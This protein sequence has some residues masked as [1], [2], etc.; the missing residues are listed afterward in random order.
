MSSV[1]PGANVI[2]SAVV[3]VDADT[4]AFNKS[5]GKI[6]GQMR[7][8]A[9]AAMSALQKELSRVQGQI[10]INQ[11][12]QVDPADPAGSGPTRPAHRPHFHRFPRKGWAP[13]P[14]RPTSD[15][16][17]SVKIDK[18]ADAIAN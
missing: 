14:G 17:K 1:G 16:G 4:L 9:R 11:V 10:K 6:P 2:A 7:A 13:R 3:T 12:R 5:I 8:Q 15:L 18:F